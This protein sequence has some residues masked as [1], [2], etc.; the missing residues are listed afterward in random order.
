[1]K[2]VWWLNSREILEGK[3][4]VLFD[5]I[6]VVLAAMG[7]ECMP[8]D[9]RHQPAFSIV[10]RQK[11]E[12]ER[13]RLGAERAGSPVLCLENGWFARVDTTIRS[14]PDRYLQACWGAICNLDHS[15]PVTPGKRYRDQPFGEIKSARRPLPSLPLLVLGQVPEDAQHK[16]TSTEMQEWYA[17]ETCLA[18]EGLG[19]P[20]DH[21]VIFRP[22]PKNATHAVDFAA[23]A[24]LPNISVDTLAPLA[25]TILGSCG[26]VS[27]NSTALL[28]VLRLGVPVLRTWGLGMFAGMTGFQSFLARSMFM[29]LVACHQWTSHELAM[30]ETW[31]ELIRRMPRPQ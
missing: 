4:R 1:M 7:Y 21:P 27:I 18:L 13:A 14:Q 23:F 9:H 29:E 5:A 20:V 2:P 12:S 16:M 17:R 15:V 6:A 11:P 19:L 30:K 26:V 25:T 28:E 24:S 10:L 3:D 8:R 31:V 22:H